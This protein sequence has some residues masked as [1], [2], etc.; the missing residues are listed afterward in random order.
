[1][2]WEGVFLGQPAL[3][4]EWQHR[5]QVGALGVVSA[6]S[7]NNCLCILIAHHRALVGGHL[8]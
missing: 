6:R 8:V 5:P 1:M 2:A 3:G 7:G 4:S